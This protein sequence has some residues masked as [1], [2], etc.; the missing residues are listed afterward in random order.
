[1][2][3]NLSL[4]WLYLHSYVVTSVQKYILKYSI[5]ENIRCICIDRTQ[6]TSFLVKP[7]SNVKLRIPSGCKAVSIENDQTIFRPGWQNLS[8]HE[9]PSFIIQ[10][11]KRCHQKDAMQVHHHRID[12]DH[13]YPPSTES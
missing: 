1:M 8:D 7:L 9:C 5:R 10:L 6:L 12:I 11:M 4:Y 3:Y 2:G 13:A